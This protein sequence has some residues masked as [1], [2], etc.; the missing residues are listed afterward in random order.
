MDFNF[1]ATEDVLK[2]VLKERV[3]QQQKWGLQEDL[4]WAEHL[5]ILVEEVGELAQAIQKKMQME[6]VKETDQSNADYEGIQV[7]AVAVKMVELLR[8]KGA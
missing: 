5:V 8:K 2:D 7:A 3:K 4:S 6:S 1:K